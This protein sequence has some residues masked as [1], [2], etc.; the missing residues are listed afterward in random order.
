MLRRYF[1]T[2]KSIKRQRSL[3]I[4]LGL[5]PIMV[6]F[7]IFFVFPIFFSFYLSL[8]RWPLLSL[9]R[10]FFGFNNYLY[11]FKDPVFWASVKNTGYYVV[12]YVSLVSIIGLGLALLVNSLG[13]FLKTVMR[14]IYFIPVITSMVATSI[15]FV[16]LYQPMFGILNYFLEYLR[17][18]PYDWIYSSTQVMPSITLMSVWKSVGYTM[19]LFLAGLTTIPQQYYEAAKIDGASQWQLFWRI[20]LPLLKPTTLFVVATG[21]IGAFQVF[22]QVFMMTRGGPGTA[23][24]VL[25]LH[26]YNLGFRFFQ[27]GQASAVAYILFSAIFIITIFEIKFFREKPVY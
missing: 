23:S 4:F 14:T 5:V 20:T 21:T 2:T 3:F 7:S 8:H 17:L 27:M 12:V 15:M 26:I 10:P 13:R 24:M 18:G 9:K 16:W 1:F 25:V 6:Y 11:A 19:V 22:T